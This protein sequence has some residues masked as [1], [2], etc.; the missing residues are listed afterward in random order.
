MHTNGA[1]VWEPNYCCAVLPLP[2]SHPPPQGCSPRPNPLCPPP[3]ALVRRGG[4]VAPATAA[5]AA[6][7]REEARQAA[8]RR[9]A[10]LEHS[11][12]AFLA[13]C[14]GGDDV[15]LV[16]PL[17]LWQLRC[18][19]IITHFRTCRQLLLT[20]LPKYATLGCFRG[21]FFFG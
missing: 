5:E 17:G 16:C 1:I 10:P 8:R 4:G 2:S 21:L 9:L 3:S 12:A 18:L 6:R 11:T 19:F 13:A 7:Q 14:R 15:P 20:P